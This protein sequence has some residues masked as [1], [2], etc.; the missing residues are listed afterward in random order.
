MIM[1]HTIR[2]NA[3]EGNAIK[4][5]MQEGRPVFG[6]W[7][8]IPHAMTVEIMAGAGYDWLIVDFEHAPL[9]IQNGLAMI[10]AMRY[11]PASPVAR[12][13][14]IDMAWVKR[15]LD[16]GFMSVMVPLI[17]TREDTEY[18]VSLAKYPPEGIRGAAASHRASGYGAYTKDYLARANK[19]IMVIIQIENTESVANVKDI[20]SV[21]GVDCLFIGPMDLSVDLGVAGDFQHPR[22]LEAFRKVEEAA[23][24]AGI[25]LGTLVGTPEDA[26]KK[27]DEGYLFL[28]ISSDVR[29]LAA[30][31]RGHGEKIARIRESR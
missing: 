11:S 17:R 28:G 7:L 23:K 13:P 22:V 15:V 1:E 25:P 29:H 6:S 2:I 4:K 8:A 21:P 14:L 12:V 5:R 19:E 26:R 30:G 20:V 24:E 9:D 16:I 27:V 18:A 31:A 3:M 10:Q